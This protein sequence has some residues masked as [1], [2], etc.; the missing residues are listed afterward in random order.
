MVGHM[1]DLQQLW[2]ATTDEELAALCDEYP[3]FLRYATLMENLSEA[4]RTGVGVPAHVQQLSPFPEPINRAIEKLLSEG[5]ALELGLQQ[6]MD[7]S[8]AARFRA[9]SIQDLPHE[10]ADLDVRYRAWCGAVAQLVAEVSAPD[11]A[12]QLIRQAFQDTAN[13]IEA[14]RKST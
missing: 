6:R 13:R 8:H 4:I 9:K 10:T 11:Q 7:E 2:T 12:R 5:A 14:L 3:G 1:A